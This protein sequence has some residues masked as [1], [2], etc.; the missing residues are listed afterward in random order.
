MMRKLVAKDTLSLLGIF[1][2]FLIALSACGGKR[3]EARV[4][5]SSNERALMDSLYIKEIEVLRP[6]WDSLC[7]Q[8]FETAV[9]RAVDSLI[10]TRL[11][12]EIRIRARINKQE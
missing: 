9:A 4:R 7:E 12:E 5:L 6:H 3:G 8:R 1:I 2:I 11:E 10:K